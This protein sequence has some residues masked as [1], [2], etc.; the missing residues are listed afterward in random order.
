MKKL[1]AWML[2]QMLKGYVALLIAIGF[3]FLL[4]NKERFPFNPFYALLIPIAAFLFVLPFKVYEYK[5]ENTF[6]KM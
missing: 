2:V 4:F 1:I 5:M 3:I 6:K